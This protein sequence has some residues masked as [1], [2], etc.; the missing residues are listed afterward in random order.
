LKE[1]IKQ[2]KKSAPKV[3]PRVTAKSKQVA[4]QAIGLTNAEWAYVV[5]ERNKK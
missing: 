4:I 1:T 5:A 2:K 3:K